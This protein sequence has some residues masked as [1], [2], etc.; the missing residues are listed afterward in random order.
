[1]LRK[2]IPSILILPFFL[3]FPYYKTL[4][5]GKDNIILKSENE[6]EK[7]ITY[8]QIGRILLDNNQELKSLDKLLSSS[9]FNL[10]SKIGKRYPKICLLYTSPSP[11]DP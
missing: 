7:I 3:N 11:R 8:E 4:A 9:T 6:D 10:A 2:L 1:M 5:K